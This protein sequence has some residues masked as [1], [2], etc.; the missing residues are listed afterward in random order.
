M[1]R[2]RIPD[3]DASRGR[4]VAAVGEIALIERVARG[5]REAFA[6][7]YLD[8]HPRLT[9]FLDRVTRRPQLVEELLN[10]TMLV[11]WRKAQTF[12]FR[13]Q[14]STWIFGIA[15]RRALKALTRVDDA[16]DFDADSAVDAE[17]PGPDMLAQQRESSALLDRALAELSADHRAVI[18]LTYYEGCS[19]KEIAAILECPVDTVKTRMFHARRRLRRL[20]EHAGGADA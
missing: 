9:R 8:Y 14:L 4:R 5:D 6:A 20:I 3:P 11:V 2:S 12:N 15:Y 7:L 16:V 1:L 17:H 18:Q 10:D 19:C 13:S